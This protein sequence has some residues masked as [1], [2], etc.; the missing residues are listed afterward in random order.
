MQLVTINGVTQVLLA[1]NGRL[2]SVA[3]ADGKQLW[4]HEWAANTIV[5]PAVIAD[6][7]VVTSQDA[8]I[9]RLAL[10]QNSGAW[11]IQERWTSN[12]LKPY[13]ND[14]VIHAT[15]AFSHGAVTCQSPAVGL[16]L[17]LSIP[18]PNSIASS[19]KWQ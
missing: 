11:T 2:T 19:L 16:L 12:G 15:S 1:S 7:V 5:Q 13:F 3:V 18:V 4:Q 10:A 9:R 8:G 17:S 6:G 14:F